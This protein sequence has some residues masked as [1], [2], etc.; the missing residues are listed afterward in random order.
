MYLHVGKG[1]TVKK[2]EIIGIFD[3]DT[4]TVSSVTKRFI[5]AKEKEKK[6]EYYD[7]ELPRSF[8]LCC[9]K[10][11]RILLSRIST[12]GLKDRTEGIYNYNEEY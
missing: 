5:N 12:G 6:L 4:S 2:N 7:T 10:E 9:G 11:E 8:I 1:K 3:L